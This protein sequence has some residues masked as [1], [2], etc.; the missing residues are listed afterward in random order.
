MKRPQQDMVRTLRTSCI[1]IALLLFH[2]LRT[3]A[4]LNVTPDVIELGDIVVGDTTSFTFSLANHGDVLLSAP[5]SYCDGDANPYVLHGFALPQTIKAH[6]SATATFAILP[7]QPAASILW[8]CSFQY[9]Q[10]DGGTVETQLS[11]RGA[12]TRSAALS[13]PAA[14]DFGTIVAGDTVERTF[15]V[16]NTGNAPGWIHYIYDLSETPFMYK[17]MPELPYRIGKGDSLTLTVA[18]VP[19]QANADT[20]TIAIETSWSFSPYIALLAGR[21]RPQDTLRYSAAFL[22]F[23]NAVPGRSSVLPVVFSIPSRSAVIDDVAV[24]GSECFELSPPPRLPC[25]VKPTVPCTVWVRCTPDRFGLLN[26]ILTVTTSTGKRI[27]VR[28]EA[29]VRPPS[30]QT[31]GTVVLDEERA[32]NGYT[33]FAPL[34]STITYLMNNKGEIVHT[35]SGSFRPAQSAMLMEGGV[36]LRTATPGDGLPLDDQG[37]GGIV[38]KI[39]WDG[40]VIWRYEY[41][42]QDQRAHHDIE[43]LP[44]GNILLLVRERQSWDSAFSAGRIPKRI[45]E[46]AVWTE[47]IVEVKPTDRRSGEIV[48]EWKAWDHLVQDAN[49]ARANYGDVAVLRERID[50]NTGPV[51]ADWLHMNSVRYNAARD[52]I[53]VSMRN[54]NEVIVIDRKTGN[55]VY[56][57]GNAINY[58][59]GDTADR[60]LYVQH[61]AR[62][63]G[64]G[65]P[66]EGNIMIFNNGRGRGDSSYSTVEEIIPPLGTDGKYVMTSPAPFG[67]STPAW[68]FQAPRNTHFYATIGGSAARLRNGNT[69]V[70]L[71]PSGSFVEVTMNGDEVWRYVSPVGNGTIY[72]QGQTP[73]NN[74]VFRATKY[75]GDGPELAGRTLR[76][77]GRLEDGPLSVIDVTSPGIS[78]TRTTDGRLHLTVTEQKYVHLDAYDLLG[79]WL[80]TIVD[81]TLEPGTYIHSVPDGTFIVK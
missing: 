50:I 33:L 2:T 12:S 25:T 18:Y 35:W 34:N 81:A 36:L 72:R 46:N 42:G 22:S 26:G 3:Q 24:T 77:L 57:W 19:T 60:R 9:R 16:V 78:C 70:C 80:G 44:N 63:I 45:T 14:V 11:I 38:E 8:T 69:L 65:M 43:L 20:A 39:G 68:S 54:M 10:P 5:Q 55:I 27:D 51:T 52:E 74:A 76:S 37:A 66:G 32:M 13:G 58:R 64:E 61:D 62:W 75:D 47:R 30:A 7:I 6:D 56:R 4:Q 1:V 23:A 31:V 73:V 53:L 21:A 49:P 17:R 40:D 59:A 71:D 29:N 15:K 41:Q 79:R 67:P 48:W 28:L